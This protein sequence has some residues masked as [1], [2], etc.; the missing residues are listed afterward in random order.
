M[1]PQLSA[2]DEELSSIGFPLGPRKRLGRAIA[3]QKGITEIARKT[4]SNGPLKA[5]E[6][7]LFLSHKQVG[8]GDLAQAIK[9]QLEIEQPN[10]KCFLDV[11]DLNMI[12]DIEA[13][14]RNSR[15]FLLLLTEGV[16][17]RPFVQKEILAALGANKNIILVHDEKS[18]PFPSGDL[19]KNV[20]PEVQK[21]LT[22]KAIPY[23]RERV[24]R[25]LCIEQ[26]QLKLND[27]PPS[28]SPPS[29]AV[30]ATKTVTFSPPT[31]A[32]P[33]SNATPIKGAGALRAISKVVNK[34]R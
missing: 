26:I 24:F 13:A 30:P 15:T 2:T 21:V 22:I 20:P 10:I 1:D 27:E 17:E 3:N 23:Y 34:P 6:Y 19:L 7:D 5:G 28:L 29:S 18:T 8:G 32:A 14:V 31:S 33:S 11:D 12:H 25:K 4:K 16:L 9:L